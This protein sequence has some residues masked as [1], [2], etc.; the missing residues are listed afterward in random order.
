MPVSKVIKFVLD[1]QIPN[2]IYTQYG[3]NNEFNR[4]LIEA[5]KDNIC[6]ETHSYC[7]VIMYVEFNNAAKAFACEANLKAVI[8]KWNGKLYE[9]NKQ[10]EQE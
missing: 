3:D 8:R 10:L 6:S 4:D 2:E 5:T 7:D 9:Y 1:F